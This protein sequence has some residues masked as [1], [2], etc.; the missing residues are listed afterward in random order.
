MLPATSHTLFPL[1]SIFS[2]V[3]VLGLTLPTLEPPRVMECGRTN[4]TVE[5]TSSFIKREQDQT[6]VGFNLSF[7]PA[8][9]NASIA[10]NSG[11]SGYMEVRKPD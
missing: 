6:S 2:I 4:C 1:T 5:W 3:K 9:A 10:G 11:G 8:T 7:V